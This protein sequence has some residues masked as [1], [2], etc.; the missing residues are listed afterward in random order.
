MLGL[1]ESGDGVL[2]N[3]GGDSLAGVLA[4]EQD[5]ALSVNYVLSGEPDGLD[6]IAALAPADLLDLHAGAAVS[7]GDPL[8]EPQEPRIGV[9][10][11]QHEL[12]IPRPGA[13]AYGEPI[14][15]LDGHV[16]SA[17]VPVE[18]V[19]IVRELGR[20]LPAGSV[21]VCQHPH[22]LVPDNVLGDVE[23][24][25]GHGK[26][27]LALLALLAGHQLQ[28]AVDDVLLAAAEARV[29]A[30]LVP[31][32]SGP[33]RVVTRDWALGGFGHEVEPLVV[34]VRVDVVLQQQVIDR[35]LFLLPGLGLRPALFHKR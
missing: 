27:R 35:L 19:A 28:V 3:V 13:F 20:I 29:R 14:P 9:G 31:L 17:V 26:L 6:V 22:A 7:M 25:E 18:L 4:G 1:G 23:D 2:D 12:D 33:G 10:V 32:V 16:V 8:A 5:D 30:A 24:Q 15:E 34:A 21:L 11:R